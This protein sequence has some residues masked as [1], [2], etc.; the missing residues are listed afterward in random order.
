VSKKQGKGGGKGHAMY[1][2]LRRIQDALDNNSPPLPFDVAPVAAALVAANP[3][4]HVVNRADGLIVR[5]DARGG[6]A[7]QAQQDS[8]DALVLGL[9]LTTTGLASAEVLAL[10]GQAKTVLDALDALGKLLRAQS[11][12][13]KDEINLLRDWITSFK[14]AVAAPT[15]TT[16]A[17]LKTAVAALPNTPD[18][19]L[20]QLRTAI[21]ARLDSGSVDA[22]P[23]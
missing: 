10:R 19:D 7:T 6:A 12:V 3:Q 4:W 17:T 1:D 9:D 8:A 21:R 16:L 14:A 22:S 2:A 15:T 20:G 5:L 11:D 18:R 13:I 23:P